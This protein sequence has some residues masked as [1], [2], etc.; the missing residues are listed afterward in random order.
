MLP[1]Y[2]MHQTVLLT[3]GYWVVRWDIPDL[4]KWIIIVGSSLTICLALYE[5]LIRRNNVLRF[6]FG[7]KSLQPASLPGALQQPAA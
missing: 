1:F 3:V 7:M 5:F 4:A 6:L 2:I